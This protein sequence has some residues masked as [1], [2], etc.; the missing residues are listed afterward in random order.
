[1]LREDHQAVSTA[2]LAGLNT[3]AIRCSDGG[4]CPAGPFPHVLPCGGGGL[5]CPSQGRQVGDSLQAHP[6]AVGDADPA[7]DRRERDGQDNETYGVDGP[8]TLLAGTFAGTPVRNRLTSRHSC[9]RNCRSKHH[10]RSLSSMVVTEHRAMPPTQ[11]AAP[12]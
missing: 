4:G 1:M 6:L 10:G 3:G 11:P 5:L 2:H 9:T 7:E 12:R 8:G